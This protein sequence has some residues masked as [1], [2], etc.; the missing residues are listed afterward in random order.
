MYRVQNLVL[1]ASKTNL[2]SSAVY[3]EVSLDAILKGESG[4][5]EH[6]QTLNLVY[7][8]QVKDEKAEALSLE[9]MELQSLVPSSL[10]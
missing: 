4:S 9:P 8:S 5:K 2:S 7:I 1:Q 6:L 3:A 10:E